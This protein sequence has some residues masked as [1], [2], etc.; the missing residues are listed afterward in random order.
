MTRRLDVPAERGGNRTCYS[1]GN[2][3]PDHVRFCPKDSAD[4]EYIPQPIE[5]LAVDFGRPKRCKAVLI[6][7]II[8][9]ITGGLLAMDRLI[10]MPVSSAPAVGELT[11]RTIPSGARVYLD[12][13]HVGVSPVR[14]SDIPTG[15]HEVRAVFP[16]YTDGKAHVEILPSAAQKLVWDLAPLPAS[17]KTDRNKYL[18]ELSSKGVSAAIEVASEDSI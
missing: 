10:S 17:K 5:K 8:V 18:A 7:S 9:L 1:C 16:G 4:L 13:S 6:F 11:V 2:S 12:G 15:V 3:Y 14:L